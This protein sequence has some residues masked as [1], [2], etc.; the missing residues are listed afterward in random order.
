MRRQR[1]QHEGELGLLLFLLLLNWGGSGGAMTS[2]TVRPPASGSGDG[3]KLT[4]AELRA[5]AVQVGFPDPDVAAAVAMA[6]S[7]GNPLAVRLS[8]VEASYGLWQVNVR[9]HS[10]YNAAE[11]GDPLYNAQ[12]ALAIRNA[13]GGWSPWTT[14]TT[15]AYRKY[16]PGG[17][18][19]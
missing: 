4:L 3:G 2:P 19:A 15:G 10:S 6:E 1:R 16:M 17:T 12:A 8:N 14:Y 11:L 7:G 13:A 18:A 9:A 5:L